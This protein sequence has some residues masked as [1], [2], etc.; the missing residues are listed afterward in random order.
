MSI[1]FQ[2]VSFYY[3]NPE[4]LV[5]KNLSVT[6][7]EGGLT[8]LIG[9]NGTGKSTF[10]LLAAGRLLPKEGHISLG[11]YDTKEILSE[12]KRNLMASFIYQNME[13]ETEETIG[14]L[15][16]LVFENGCLDS[17]KSLIADEL[18]AELELEN[19]LGKRFYQTSKGEM[20]KINIA[21]SLLYGAPVIFMDEPVFA[22]ENHWK[23][24]ILA[25]LNTYVHKHGIT[26]YYSIHEID[27]S[28]KYSDN[29][30]LFFKNGD[31]VLGPTDKL[32]QKKNLEEA[33]QV[34]LELLYQ[35]ESLFRDHLLKSVD[36]EGLKNMDHSIKIIE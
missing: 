20:Q 9:Q 2:N 5:F 27:L 4:S 29:G 25:Y 24:R 3:E 11:G 6:L 23:D 1:Q 15:F 30:I 22:L 14:E 19:I 36:L 10:M 16:E 17:S 12:E 18:I 26:L 32:L 8:S 35:R 34:P 33:Y 31:I 13:F 28:R 7:P 21:F